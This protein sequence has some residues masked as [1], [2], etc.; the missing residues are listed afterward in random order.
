MFNISHLF[1]VLTNGLVKIM[2]IHCR[3][4]TVIYRQDDEILNSQIPDKGDLNVSKFSN[5]QAMLCI[6]VSGSLKKKE[7]K[8]T[9]RKLVSV[10]F[11]E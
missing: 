11:Y 3:F 1:Y 4:V 10:S 2:E 9:K 6:T 7:K 5:R 8:K